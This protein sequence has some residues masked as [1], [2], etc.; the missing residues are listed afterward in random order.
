ML[1]TML[2]YSVAST[3]PKFEIPDKFHVE[4]GVDI[5]VLDR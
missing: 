2:S 4:L 5:G 1:L 3:L